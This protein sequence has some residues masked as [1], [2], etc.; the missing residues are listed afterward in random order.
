MTGRSESEAFVYI[1]VYASPD[2]ARMDHAVLQR[3]RDEKVIEPFD[4]GLVYRDE[5]GDTHVRKRERGMRKGVVSGIG[6]GALL[7]V[8]I[9]FAA[10]PMTVSINATKG[11]LKSYFKDGMSRQDI[12]ELGAALESGEAALIVL[13]GEDLEAI[14]N[15]ELSGADRSIQRRVQGQADELKTALENPV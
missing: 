5:E 9:P 13:S 7:G 12:K 8:L 2:R 10:I 11:G 3:L 4:V 6:I 15:L 1:A 14:L